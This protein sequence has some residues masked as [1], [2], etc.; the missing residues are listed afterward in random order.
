MGKAIG[1]DLGT[2]NSCAAHVVKGKPKVIAQP[3][4]LNSLP[5]VYTIDESGREIVGHEAKKLAQ[6]SP[7]NTVM[8]SKRLIGRNFHNKDID[9]IRQLFTYE[10]IEGDNSEVLVKIRDRLLTLEHISAAILKRIKE[11]AEAQLKE[12]ID[13][14]VITVPAYFNER[15]RQAVRDAG[16]MAN[17]DVLRII[18]E[19]TAAALS[20][21]VIKG[22]GKRIAVYDLGGG[23]FDMSVID[24][25]DTT[26]KVIATGGDTFLGGVDFDDRLMQYLLEY[27]LET[28][29]IDLSFDRVAVQRIRDA[30]EE[31]KIKLSTVH[32]TRVHIPFISES[33]DEE[34]GPID[35]DMALTR[36]KLESLTSDLVERSVQ[37][38]RQILLEAATPS[39]KLDELLLV[40]GQSR[41]PLVQAK[42]EEFLGKLPTKG[43]H[44]DE[45]VALGAALMAHSITSDDRSLTL[46]DVLPM[47]IGLRKGNGQMHVLFS[48]N[49]RLPTD[50]VQTLTTFRD[51]Q[52]TIALR[53][54]QG[55][56]M[57]V[58]DNELLGSYVFSGFELAPKGQVKLRVHFHIDPE[59]ILHVSAT[60]KSTGDKIK[61]IVL[62]HRSSVE[63]QDTEPI[64][65]S[66]D[67]IETKKIPSPP[68]DAT[69]SPKLE[70]PEEAIQT[71]PI[72]KENEKIKEVSNKERQRDNKSPEPQQAPTPL[73]SPDSIKTVT[74]DKE[75]QQKQSPK[76]TKAEPAKVK[77]SIPIH[78]TKPIG[79]KAYV[80]SF[81]KWLLS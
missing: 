27:F 33:E 60:N 63:S 49:A 31:A 28:H 71:I 34:S 61:T 22:D 75:E 74:S 30:A 44:P 51:N 45:A 32:S 55:E 78:T 73:K 5:S 53:L 16:M 21:G 1:I 23:T 52:Q 15:Q 59:G 13:A 66:Q 8:A 36:K 79:F 11:S 38:C 46:L 18:N 70:D 47:A 4:G 3:G 29:D 25:K 69:E 20:Y 26:F 39:D 12:P 7:L 2:T 81:I 42:L 77:S 65:K 6:Q 64:S 54:Y 14:A 72:K 40:G 50:K 24:I 57:L 17:I 37:A 19:P 9:D 56:S 43:V 80:S 58:K 62:S 68:S 10:V 35:L 41:M 67:E 76:T 48:K